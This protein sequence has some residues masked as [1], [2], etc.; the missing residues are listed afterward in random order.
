[1]ATVPEKSG[2][3]VASVFQAGYPGGYLV[4]SIGYGALFSLI[5]WRG[6]SQRIGAGRQPRG[7]SGFGVSDR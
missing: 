4:V 5:G 3:W 2:G 7:I 6:L 1:M